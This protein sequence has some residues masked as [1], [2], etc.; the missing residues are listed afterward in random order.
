LFDKKNSMNKLNFF[1]SI[2]IIAAIAAAVFVFAGAV[3]YKSISDEHSSIAFILRNVN[4]SQRAIGSMINGSV[5]PSA[6]PVSPLNLAQPE[7]ST[8]SVQNIISPDDCR[9]IFN[10]KAAL[11]N[12]SL[13]N[14]LADQGPKYSFEDRQQIAKELGVLDYRGT[15]CQNE[16]ILMQ[17]FLQAGALPQKNCL[18]ICSDQ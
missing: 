3:V 10:E 15:S 13:V 5:S 16:Q 17:L 1:V 2:L 11:F 14:Y 9:E 8:Q 7:P 12:Y 6:R 18:P 4:L